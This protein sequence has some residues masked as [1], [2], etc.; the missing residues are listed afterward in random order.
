MKVLV[1]GGA[2]YIGSRLV[3]TL[4]SRHHEVVVFDKFR[5]GAQSLMGYLNLYNLSLI[6]GD[7]RSKSDLFAALDGVDAVV[8]LASIVGEDAC[9]A[10]K[11]IAQDVNEKA[12]VLIAECLKMYPVSKF[13]FI[14][15]CSNY[16]VSEPNILVDENS[17]LNPLSEYANSKVFSEQIFLNEL[18]SNGVTILRLGTICG[19]SPK[20]RFDLLVNEM[21][22]N[23][24]LGK[25]INIFGPESWRPFLHIDDAA[26]AIYNILESSPKL[27]DGRVFNVVGENHK[28]IDL[29]EIIKKSYPNAKIFITNKKPDLRDYRVN[30]N[31]YAKLFNHQFR[32]VHQAFNEITLAVKANY[33]KDP[34]WSG[35]TAI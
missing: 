9:L 25:T 11:D 3:P 30:G 20:M 7:I 6:C 22:R 5:F 29:I 34:M 14:S 10:N 35:H 24:I 2:G 32:S 16:G 31:L 33:F 28:K 23:V 18:P 4:L 27:S 19:L 15:T 8:H 1:I 26:I 13:I 21:A 17:P 12:N